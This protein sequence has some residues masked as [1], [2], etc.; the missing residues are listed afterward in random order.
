[1]NEDD[2]NDSEGVLARLKNEATKRLKE[3]ERAEDAAD[4]ALLRFGSN[5]RNFLRDAVTI[6]PPSSS[7]NTESGAV[8]FESKDATGKRIIHTTRFD[9]QL[10]AIHTCLDSF[11]KDPVSVEYEPWKTSF[12]VEEN[13][14]AISKY[15]K[16]FPEL[17]ISMEKLVPDIVPYVDFWTRYHFLRHTIETAEARRKDLLKGISSFPIMIDI[18]L[19]IIRSCSFL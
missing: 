6:A 18:I 3:I 7:S 11:T 16:T 13:T 14:E 8:V 9:A 17:R 1:M 5:I 15:L 19:T 10:Y 2:T 4:E 12:N